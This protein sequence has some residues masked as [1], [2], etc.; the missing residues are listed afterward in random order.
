MLYHSL[1]KAPAVHGT[2]FSCSGC[3]PHLRWVAELSERAWKGWVCLS[4]Q[5]N[6]RSLPQDRMWFLMDKGKATGQA[7]PCVLIYQIG[8]I[9]SKFI[10]E[11]AM[12]NLS[13]CF[14]Q[15]LAQNQI[16]STS[17]AS[18]ANVLCGAYDSLSS[19]PFL[20]GF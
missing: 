16:L 6:L 9:S 10:L 14:P 8:E 15:R 7:S 1:W 11:V 17:G 2:Q 3:L 12:E 13:C 19:P 18:K 20:P 4:E 5:H